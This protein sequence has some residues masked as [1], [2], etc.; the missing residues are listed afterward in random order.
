MRAR[1]LIAACFLVTAAAGIGTALYVYRLDHAPDPFYPEA[2]ARLEH[3][4]ATLAPP[5]P[6]LAPP[7]SAARQIPL[8]TLLG[9][10]EIPRL[11]IS[12]PVLEGADNPGLRRSAAHITGTG[13]PGSSGN[14]GIAAHRDTYFRPLRF[15]KPGDEIIVQTK[16]GVYR[17]QVSR[18]EIVDPSDTRVLASTGS[19]E[20]TLVTCYPFF[21]VGHAP[22]RFIVHARAVEGASRQIRG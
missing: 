12:L 13:L 5:A 17:Y 10:I 22:K 19:P 16:D 2:L 14:I 9:R 20:L 15:I 8:H 7:P 18:Y 11:K 6:Q 1:W 21:Y 4:L 3:K